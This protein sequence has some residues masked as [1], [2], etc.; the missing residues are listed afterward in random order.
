MKEVEM[1]IDLARSQLG[2]AEVRTNITKYAKDFDEKWPNF[3]NTK[4]QGASWCDIFVDWLFCESFGPTQAMKMLYQPA[5]SCGAGCKF[6]AAYYRNNKAFDRDPKPGDQIFF[7]RAGAESHTGIVVTVT[8]TQV[9]T[10]EGNSANKVMMHVYDKMNRSI[11]GYGHP[12]YDTEVVVAEKYQGE[13]PTLPKRGYFQKGD[14]GVNV[15][16]MQAFL[17]WYDP[18]FLPKYGI[19]GDFGHETTTAVVMFQSREGL[20]PD[21]L[22]GK[23]SLARAKLV[24]K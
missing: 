2:Y 9:T 1:I 19:D 17:K 21:G 14:K 6:S 16:R 22:F 4:K 18:T 24:L 20:T 11:V 10:I 23:K 12:K 7:G 15:G 13:W 5:K 3:Y 8:A